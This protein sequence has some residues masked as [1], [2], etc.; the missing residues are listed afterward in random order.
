MSPGT[1]SAMERPCYRIDRTIAAVQETAEEA[2]RNL[3]KL[4]K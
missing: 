3:H 4:S 1:K 2:V